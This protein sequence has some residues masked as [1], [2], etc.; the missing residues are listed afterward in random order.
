MSVIDKLKFWKK[1]EPLPAPVDLSPQPEPPGMQQPPGMEQLGAPQPV[2]GVTE[3]PGMAPQRDQFQPPESF[4]KSDALS[5]AQ[6]PGAA[7]ASHEQQMQLISSKLDTIKAQLETVIQ[8]LDRLEQKQNGR[9]Y[10]Q[11][12]RA[13]M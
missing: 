8:R 6:P 7:P 13:S 3:P 9:P 1:E 5:H 10:E 4:P 2:P 12:W 11:R